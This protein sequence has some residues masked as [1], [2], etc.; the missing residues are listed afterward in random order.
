MEDLLKQILHEIKDVKSD[1]SYL[2][3]GQ[4]KLELSQERIETRIDKVELSQQRIEAKIDN[5]SIEIY[6][7]F[8]QTNNNIKVFQNVVDEISSKF[9]KLKNNNYSTKN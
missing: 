8:T 6:S 9:N 4:E 2:K 3:Q 7:N 1:I 5:L